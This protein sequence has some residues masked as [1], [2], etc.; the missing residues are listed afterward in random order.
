M[1]MTTFAFSYALAPSSAQ[2]KQRTL[3]ATVL[4]A[5]GAIVGWP[6]ALALAVPFVF[7]ELFIFSADRVAP[8]IRMPWMFNRWKRLFTAGLAAALIFV[9]VL[10]IH[11]SYT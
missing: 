4:F 7:E 8:E 11:P 6:F 10:G 9:S 5:T 3:A 2:N 1:Y